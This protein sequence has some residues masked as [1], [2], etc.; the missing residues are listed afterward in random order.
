MILLTSVIFHIYFLR[1]Y[2]GKFIVFFCTSAAW[3]TI[4]LG[5]FYLEGP[6]EVGMLVGW[7]I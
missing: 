6:S 2:F 5:P 1:R 7:G 3:G 4:I